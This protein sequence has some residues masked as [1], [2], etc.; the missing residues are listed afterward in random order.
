MISNRT[1]ERNNVT[2]GFMRPSPPRNAACRNFAVSPC[3][4]RLR[5]LLDED[6]LVALEVSLDGGDVGELNGH[7]FGIDGAVMPVM[8]EA[9]A[10]LQNLDVTIGKLPHLPLRKL[11]HFSDLLC[12]HTIISARK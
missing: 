10:N 11:L 7:P 9:L 12:S 5:P 8:S 3:S 6:G 1:Q 2:K 4:A